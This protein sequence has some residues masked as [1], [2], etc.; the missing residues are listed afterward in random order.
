MVISVRGL[1]SSIHS[2]ASGVARPQIVDMPTANS[3]IADRREQPF[4][5]TK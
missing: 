4:I 1:S 3:S 2:G 5:R